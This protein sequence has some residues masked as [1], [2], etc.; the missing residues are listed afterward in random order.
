MKLSEFTRFNDCTHLS[1]RRLRASDLDTGGRDS[2]YLHHL[3]FPFLLSFWLVILKN[4]ARSQARSNSPIICVVATDPFN[5]GKIIQ[6]R[7][8]YTPV[9]VVGCQCL[10]K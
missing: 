5:L 8:V 6:H 1:R 10:V 7:L 3:I 2:K 4:Q 9:V